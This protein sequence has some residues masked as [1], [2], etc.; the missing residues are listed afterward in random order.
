MKGK[1]EY[2]KIFRKRKNKKINFIYTTLCPRKFVDKKFIFD[3]KIL[4]FGSGIESPNYK[5]TADDKGSYFGFDIDEETVA[6]LKDNDFYVDFWKT[7]EKFD[8]IMASEVYEHLDFE[9]RENFIERASQLVGPDGLL[10]VDFPYIHNLDGSFY[11]LDR[12]HLFPPSPADESSLIELYGFN[13]EIYVVGI[14]YWPP[15]RI[16]RIIL[17]LLLGYRP[18]HTTILGCS[19]QSI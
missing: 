17:N 7:E 2:N 13:A 10:I 4:D 19:K 18:Q 1:E 15:Y 12:T 6:W 5:K 14:A 16:L 11:W 9:T 8:I 3:K